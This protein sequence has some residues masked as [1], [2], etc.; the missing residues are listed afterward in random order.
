MKKLKSVAGFCQ[1][2]DPVNPG[3]ISTV[4]VS[5][6][7]VYAPAIPED[8]TPGGG[9][10]PLTY[11]LGTRWTIPLYSCA[12]AVKASIKTVE[13]KLNG[14]SLPD[15]KV[16]AIK[17]KDFSLE[18][19]EPVWAVESTNMKLHDGV[20]LWGLVDLKAKRPANVT[21]V[22]REHLWL[23]GIVEP[24]G[25]GNIDVENMPSVDF[26]ILALSMLGRIGG[27]HTSSGYTFGFT[28]GG[29]SFGLGD[30]SGTTNAAM[31]RKWQDLAVDADGVAR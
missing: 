26:P 12:T 14:T 18:A 11:D 3:N 24:G 2:F 22:R 15:L 27:S 16:Q 5:C 23:P 21:T 9:R 6:S 13:F 1:H 7:M 4:A 30:Y 10:Y 19:N 17:G 25:Q 31:F 28:S 29:G 8:S 20:P